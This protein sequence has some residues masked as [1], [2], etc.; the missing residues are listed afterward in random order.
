MIHDK[1]FGELL[2]TVTE[3]SFEIIKEIQENPLQI[4]ALVN[5][6]IE[7]TEH[8]QGV[9]TVILN[10]PEKIGDMQ[11]AY[12]QDVMNLAQTQWDHWL[13]GT[14]IPITD[15]R[16][17]TEDWLQNPLFNLL[18]QQYLLA[19]QHMNNLFKN[20]E[21]SDKNAAKRLQFYT[22]QYLDALSPANFLQ[23]NPQLIDETLKSHG[24][25]LLQGLHNLLNDLEVGS[26][27]L[28][29]K[30]TDAEAFKIGKNL[31]TTPGKVVFR[32]DMMEL[33]QFLPQTDKVKSI[34]LLMI[35][36]WINKY[37]ILD[38][39]A[40]NSFIRWIVEQGITVFVISWVNPDASFAK[41]SLY[42]Y[43]QEGP[44]EAI[45]VIKKQLNVP[46]V[47]TLGFCIGGTLL[48]ILLAYN[49]AHKDN[50]IHSATFL[51]SM[52]DFSDPGDISVFIDEQQIQK[53]EQE[54]KSK[55]Y[56]AG[57]F[58][59]SSF[60]SLRANDLVWSFLLKITYVEKTLSLLISYIGTLTLRICQRLCIRNIYVGCICII[61]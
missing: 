4:P 23:T 24:K 34:P 45:Q 54:M 21:Y 43:L 5:Q 41:K 10:N 2:Q 44:Q 22:K 11:F 18:S 57:K 20:M 52:I 27:R 36:P 53:L 55:G 3:K 38:L 61:I 16:F 31:A 32:N 8:F 35:P 51:A 7:L 56:L 17:N 49:K 12:W 58:M 42:D 30:M 60:N 19:S 25:N 40:H 6:Y 1:E 26:S 15:A 28:N 39:S 48:S 59:A 29:I 37:Y 33:I 14:P 13:A 50:S 9:M 46:H 47:N